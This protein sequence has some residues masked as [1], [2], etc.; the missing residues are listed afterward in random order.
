MEGR[1]G[2]KIKFWNDEWLDKCSLMERFLKLYINSN[3][4][5]AVV[6]EVRFWNRVSWNLSRRIEWFECVRNIVI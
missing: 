1:N 4:K 3:I 5:D 6:R 2:S